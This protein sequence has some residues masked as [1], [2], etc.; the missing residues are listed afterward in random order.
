MF[1]SIWAHP[2]HFGGNHPKDLPAEGIFFSYFYHD[3]EPYEF[4]AQV[5]RFVQ[6][7]SKPVSISSSKVTFDC[8]EHAEAALQANPKGPWTSLQPSYQSQ[9]DGS[10]VQVGDVQI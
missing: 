7:N 5:V 4:T 10:L 2:S 9:R 3:M 8:P 6:H 1:S